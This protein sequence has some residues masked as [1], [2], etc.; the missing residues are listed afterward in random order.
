[1]SEKEERKKLRHCSRIELL[2]ML[3]ESR[4]ENAALLEENQKLKQELDQ[5]ILISSEAGN[6]AREALA[7]N[8]IFAYAQQAA[9]DYLHAVKE[10]YPKEEDV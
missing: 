8:E 3:L 4:K 1:M 10:K 9:E 6:L 2:E 7:L 5:R